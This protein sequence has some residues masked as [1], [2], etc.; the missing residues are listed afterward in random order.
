[1]RI[2]E[3]SLR[4]TRNGSFVHVLK[5]SPADFPSPIFKLE[6]PKPM[7]VPIE[8]RHQVYTA[9]L[10]EL[11]L[12]DDH[13]SH[14]TDVRRLSDATIARQFYASV[15]DPG[16]LPQVCFRLSGRFDLSGVPG[17]YRDGGRWRINLWSPGIII[18]VR[19]REERIQAL[20]IR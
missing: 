10:D 15:P 16:E 9:L 13:S 19:D 2:S 11:I 14:L 20:S 4:Q 8:R 1:M 18:P 12:S 3:G 17:F 6:R 7:I 5:D